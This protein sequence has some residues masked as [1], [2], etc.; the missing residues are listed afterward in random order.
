MSHA[1]RQFARIIMLKSIMDVCPRDRDYTAS[2]TS[3]I[4]KWLRIPM[5]VQR[6]S[7]CCGGR[8]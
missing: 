5:Q 1:R 4:S 7:L 3:M 6:P 2:I 8:T